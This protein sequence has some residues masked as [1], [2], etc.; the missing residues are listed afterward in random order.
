MGVL[1]MAPAL[2]LGFV[3]VWL[4]WPVV[5]EPSLRRMRVIRRPKAESADRIAEALFG[6]WSRH[7]NTPGLVNRFRRG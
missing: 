4:L 2:L 5:V 1:H 7:G 6:T 3:A